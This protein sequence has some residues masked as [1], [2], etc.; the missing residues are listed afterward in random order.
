ME[1]VE[2]W[3]QAVNR[4]SARELGVRDSGA[5]QIKEVHVT[6]FMCHSNMR[7]EFRP[8]VNFISG[9]NGSGK[10]AILQA[11]Q[12]CLGVRATSTG[13]AKSNAEYLKKGSDVCTASVRSSLHFLLQSD[14]SLTFQNVCSTR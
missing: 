6:N 11:L 13:R 1:L 10:S 4:F 5:G 3:L 12:Y 9:P 2:I 14:S 7:V 8:H